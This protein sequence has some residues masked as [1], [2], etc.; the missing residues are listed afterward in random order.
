MYI[1]TVLAVLCGAMI[2]NGNSNEMDLDS[3]LCIAQ[4]ESNYSSSFSDR[5]TESYLNE[6]ASVVEEEEE[7]FPSAS[8]RKRRDNDDTL[9]K[10]RVENFPSA[11]D[12]IFKRVVQSVL[13]ADNIP[14]FNQTY[15]NI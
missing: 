11:K 1:S 2:I 7:N 3:N 14:K 5:E 6:S 12:F 4:S 9:K 15:R 10:R 8:K 13:L